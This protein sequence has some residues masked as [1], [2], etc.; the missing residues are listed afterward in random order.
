MYIYIYICSF[1]SHESWLIPPVFTNVEVCM[2]QFSTS[3]QAWRW[4]IYIL[5][6]AWARRAVPADSG[7]PKGKSTGIF[8]PMWAKQGHKPSPKSP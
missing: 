1:I 6:Q 3:P 5:D 7:N 4:A 2:A 8:E